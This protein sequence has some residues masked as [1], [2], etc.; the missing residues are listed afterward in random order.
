MRPKLQYMSTG[1]AVV[2]LQTR[3]NLLMPT[4]FPLLKVDG[5]FGDKTLTRVKQFQGS[6]ALVRDGIVGAK[7]WAAIDGQAPPPGGP[8]PKAG[9]PAPP[10]LPGWD[11]LF[12]LVHSGALMY[13]THGTDQRGIKVNPPTRPANVWD[14]KAVTNIPPF[15]GCYSLANPSVAKANQAFQEA[16]GPLGPLYKPW[17]PG[18]KKK[19][20]Q[21]PIP[22]ACSPLVIAGWKGTKR[23]EMVGT[24]PQRALDK[25]CKADC[26]YGGVI[27]FVT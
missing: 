5:K 1:A 12:P 20:A 2:E 11:Y 18:E 23:L 13:C 6:R 24:P 3:L 10:T 22:G 7:T 4:A 25:T 8:Q 21:A 27:K 15:G 26:S 17:E 16:Q 14:H 19:Y 9:P